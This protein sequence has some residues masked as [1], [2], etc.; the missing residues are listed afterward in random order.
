MYVIPYVIVLGC[1]SCERYSIRYVM[2]L[3]YVL[4]LRNDIM[5]FLMISYNYH[6]R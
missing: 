1:M 3:F 2:S 4:E 6:V 5:V